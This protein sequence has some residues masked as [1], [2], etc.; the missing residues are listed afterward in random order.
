MQVPRMP[1]ALRL[2]RCGERP[3][4]PLDDLSPTSVQRPSPLLFGAVSLAH[5]DFIHPVPSILPSQVRKHCRKRHLEWL[6]QIDRYS[7]HEVRMQH[8][9]TSILEGKGGGTKIHQPHLTPFS[10]LS[11]LAEGDAKAGAI[12]CLGGRRRRPV[13]DSGRCYGPLHAR[14]YRP[15][16]SY[17][18]LTVPRWRHFITF[19]AIYVACWAIR[20]PTYFLIGLMAFVGGC[21]E[22]GLWSWRLYAEGLGF[23]CEAWLRLCA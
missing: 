21:V 10:H 1:Q 14:R 19:V 4:R 23:L 8:L 6:R 3:P 7:A 2:H 11:L 18:P 15:L 16:S 5:D 20:N 9:S 17:S 22:G 12:L 13:S